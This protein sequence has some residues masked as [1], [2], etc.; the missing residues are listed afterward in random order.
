MADRFE[1]AICLIEDARQRFSSLLVAY[2]ESLHEKQISSNLQIN[3]K[4]ILENLRSALDYMAYQ[5]YDQFGTQR[6]GAKVY[7]PISR[8]GGNRSDFKSLVEKNI[9][10]LSGSRPD[11]VSALEN[12]QCFSSADADWLP[13][14][15]TLAIENK[16]VQLTPQIRT[17]HDR[18]VAESKMGK[19]DWDP[20]MCHFGSGARVLNSP[21]D[22]ST[23]LPIPDA[24]HTLRHEK[25]V[26][27]SFALVGRSVLPFLEECINGVEGIVNRIRG[28]L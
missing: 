11:I 14:F 21:I 1:Q 19:V 4:N 24:Q 6:P 17:E 2:Q 12:F 20:K 27:F 9:P 7:F 10:G 28:V 8:K 13:N 3:V 26:D 25:W 15:A 16:H 5:L 18:I 23:Q 22:I